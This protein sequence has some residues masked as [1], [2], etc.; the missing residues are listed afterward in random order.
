MIGQFFFLQS[1][2]WEFIR[3]PISSE[4]TIAFEIPEKCSVQAA[5]SC[6]LSE[7]EEE[8]VP[9]KDLS[10]NVPEAPKRK[11]RSNSLLVDSEVR[12]SP[13][14]VI[15]NEGYKDHSNCTDKNCLSCHAAPPSMNLNVVKNLAV[16]FCKVSEE[17]IDKNLLKKGKTGAKGKGSQAP[18]TS[19]NMEGKKKV[20]ASGQGAKGKSGAA[21]ASAQQAKKKPSK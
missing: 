21:G 14:L 8:V 16:S 4:K 1:S 2:L 20:T 12:R 18:S 13:R 19:T 7:L 3:E 17:G 11:R 10:P 15:L 6:T 9:G 5:P